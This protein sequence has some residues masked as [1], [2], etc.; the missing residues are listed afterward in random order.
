MLIF[1]REMPPGLTSAI[2]LRRNFGHIS[3]LENRKD[4]SIWQN[5]QNI[6]LDSH[7]NLRGKNKAKLDS[8]ANFP[9]WLPP[10]LHVKHTGQYFLIKFV[11]YLMLK[12][13][14]LWFVI[15]RKY[16][17]LTR[18]KIA[19]CDLI[20]FTGTRACFRVSRNNW[21]T[22]RGPKFGAGPEIHADPRVQTRP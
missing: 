19:L 22:L 10:G 17:E 5:F 21:S 4:K 13:C 14:W 8:R 3:N 9:R 6:V 7:A 16:V 1:D 2:C 12:T 20:F 11:R 15:L 18:L